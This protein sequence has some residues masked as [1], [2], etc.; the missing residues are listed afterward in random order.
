MQYDV[1]YTNNK[2]QNMLDQGKGVNMDS[3][4]EELHSHIFSFENL[5]KCIHTSKPETKSET[6]IKSDQEH[7]HE[8]KDISVVNRKRKEVFEPRQKDGLFW[9]FYVLYAGFDKYEMIG[10]QHF[11]EEKQL[12]FKLIELIRSKKDVL[13]MH[14]IRPLT[15]LEDDLANKHQI[16]LK[17]FIALCIVANISVFVVD[18]HKYY[19]S[20]H[21]SADNVNTNVH[22]I[23]KST[24]EP[25]KYSMD[26]L[27][28][29]EKINQYRETYYHMTTLDNK[30]KS[31]TSYKSDELLEICQKL[32]IDTTS[33]KKKTKADL[34]EMIIMNL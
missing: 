14:K 29:P 4:L 12:K 2:I 33:T 32:G 21:V 19:E 25:V 30:L 13:K 27:S 7:E 18:K 6:K 23:H 20:I 11:V 8:H 10:N 5:E 24:G 34:Y 17:T 3:I 26:L 9:C 16:T 15:E 1:V 28:T 22:I 31:I